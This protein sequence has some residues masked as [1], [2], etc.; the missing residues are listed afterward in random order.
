VTIF[1]YILARKNIFCYL[2]VLSFINTFLQK[3]IFKSLP[4][5]LILT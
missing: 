1:S 2:K 4:N 5:G 3:K